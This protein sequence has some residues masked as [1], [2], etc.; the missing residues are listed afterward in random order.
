MANAVDLVWDLTSERLTVGGALVLRQEGEML[1]QLQGRAGIA[2]H[3]AC[4]ESDRS[5]AERLAQTIFGVSIFPFHLVHSTVA[6][7]GWPQALVRS[8]SD[9]SYFSFLRVIALYTESGLRPRLLWCKLQEDLARQMRQGFPGRLICVHLRSVAPFSPEESNADGPTWNAFFG[10]HANAGVCDF[11]LI[12][13]DPL[14]PGLDLRPGVSRAIDHQ[15]S[16]A[17]QLALI[18]VSDGFLGMAS[19]LCTAANFSETPYIIFKHPIHHAAEMARELGTSNSFPF[20]GDSQ[21]LWRCEA[22]AFALDEAFHLM[23]S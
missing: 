12:G 4:K 7:D 3:L 13:D 1:A 20:A 15:L 10:R 22:N 6:V 18:G 23:S 8:Q 21:Q 9:F 2:V 17:S 11:L 5:A 19:G 16:L 14:P